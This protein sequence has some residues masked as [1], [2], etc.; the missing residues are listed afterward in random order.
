MLKY[1][2]ST[3]LGSLIGIFGNGYSAMWKFSTATLIL[4]EMMSEGQDCRFN[5]S[6]GLE[7]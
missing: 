1:I 2:Y 3:D 5:N 6:R 4:H 7:F